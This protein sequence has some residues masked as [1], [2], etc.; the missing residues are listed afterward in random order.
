[1][2]VADLASIGQVVGSLAVVASLIFVGLQVRQNT[3][4]SK[5]TRLQMNAD[6]WLAY[7]TT[8]ADKRFSDDY[9][10]GAGCNVLARIH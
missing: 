1:M 4:G 5:A 6:Y 10:R 8:L 9:S 2:T 7:L 3:R